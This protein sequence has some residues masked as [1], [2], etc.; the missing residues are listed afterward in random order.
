MIRL[1]RQNLIANGKVA[2]SEKLFHGDFYTHWHDF[3]EF[4][5]F[6]EGGGDYTIDGIR[7]EI[8][9]GML[10]F[11]APVNFHSV[12][13]RN[14]RLFNVMFS[15]RLCSLDLLFRL[16]DAGFPCALR[17]KESDRPFFTALFN[18]LVDNTQ[19]EEYAACLLNAILGKLIQCQAPNTKK[20][21]PISHAAIYILNHF[22]ENLSLGEMARLAGFTPTYFSEMF[23]KETGFTFKEYTDRL[24]FDYAKK[25]VDHS[26]LSV[27][28]ICSESGFDDYANFIRRF[29]KR[30]GISPG[31]LKSLQ[32]NALA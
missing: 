17:T 2:A 8:E 3:Y 22:R 23:R 21:S 14:G 15:E 5:F 26:D 27:Q 30:F 18:E 29:K 28:Q 25:L 16:L 9:P 20:L 10:F 19:N 24:R 6:L 4:E 7:H 31:K 32:K 12:K 1:S 11:M 13:A